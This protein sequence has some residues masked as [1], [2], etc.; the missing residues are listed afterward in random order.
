MSRAVFMLKMVWNG[1]DALPE[2][3]S[4]WMNNHVKNMLHMQTERYAVHHLIFNES[5]IWL[6]RIVDLN[7]LYERKLEPPSFNQT[8]RS[9]KH[10]LF[11]LNHMYNYNY[12]LN[13]IFRKPILYLNGVP[14]LPVILDFC[15]QS[16][17]SIKLH[18][19]NKKKTKLWL[20]FDSFFNSS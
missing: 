12:Y 10:S 9:A 13:L 16:L 15:N 7:L 4:N 2:F 1:R 6:A 14:I 19:D 11:I 8:R 3:M 20:K 5:M 18:F 17:F